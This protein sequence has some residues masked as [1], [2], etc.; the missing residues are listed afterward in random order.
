MGQIRCPPFFRT[1]N[2]AF[3]RDLGHCSTGAAAAHALKSAVGIS[4]AQVHQAVLT[5]LGRT[6]IYSVLGD[7]NQYPAVNALEISPCTLHS[8]YC[9]CPQLWVLTSSP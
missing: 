9:C 3:A 2:I 8:E 4:S 1:L 7:Q 5:C 6:G